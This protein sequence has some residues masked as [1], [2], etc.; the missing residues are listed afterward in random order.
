MIRFRGQSR[1]LSLARTIVASTTVLA[2]SDSPQLSL[3]SWPCW[4]PLRLAMAAV[5]AAL[6]AAPVPATASEPAASSADGR[7]LRPRAAKAPESAAPP[8][9]RTRG[10]TSATPTPPEVEPRLREVEPSRPE[11]SP[12]AARSMALDASLA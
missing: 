3:P 11:M 2:A 5:G 12:C 8:A 6:L 10:K 4:C 9:H 7:G 1:N